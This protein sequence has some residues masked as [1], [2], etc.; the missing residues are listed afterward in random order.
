[1]S[2]GL[3]LAEYFVR[4]YNAAAVSAMQEMQADAAGELIDAID[5]S[6]SVLTLRSMLPRTA[7]KCIETIAQASAIKYISSLKPKEAAAILRYTTDEVRDALLSKLPR[8]QAIRVSMLLR[9]QSSLVGAWMETASVTF[10]GDTRIADAKGQVFD[11]AY[12]YSQIYVVDD[13]NEVIG[14]VSMVDL[15]QQKDEEQSVS[16]IMNTL[17]APIFASLTLRQAVESPVWKNSDILPVIDRDQKLIGIVRF[18]DLWGALE[19]PSSTTERAVQSHFEVLGVA[20]IYCLRLADVMVAA[21]S[22]NRRVT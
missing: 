17:V 1:M 5:D 21:L 20:E 15:L 7:A 10:R 14:A 11:E 3:K 13:L 12:V 8:R 18:I 6:L 16:S 9:Y 19:E 22:A 4:Q 2:E